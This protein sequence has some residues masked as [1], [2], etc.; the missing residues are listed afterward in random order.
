MKPDLER[1]FTHYLQPITRKK[2]KIY[3][4]DAEEN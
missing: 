2:F 1:I 4:I 3:R